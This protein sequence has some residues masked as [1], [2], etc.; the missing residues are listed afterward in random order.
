MLNCE[1]FRGNWYLSDTYLP[2]IDIDILSEKKVY[3]RDML[4]DFR[5][6]YRRE[7]QVY[8][9]KH[10]Y[11]INNTL[12]LRLFSS[13]TCGFLFQYF[14]HFHSSPRAHGPETVLRLSDMMRSRNIPWMQSFVSRLGDG[15]EY[16]LF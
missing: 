2:V 13:V 3:T 9:Y 8:G 7:G 11:M 1:Y 6:Y 12:I 5:I 14:Q 4:T 15:D 10:T 16:Q